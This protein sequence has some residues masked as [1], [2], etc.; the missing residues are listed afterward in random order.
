MNEPIGWVI[1]AAV[2]FMV[3]GMFSLSSQIHRNLQF[4]LQILESNQKA[5]ILSLEKLGALFAS[6]AHA[7]SSNRFDRRTRQ[8][9]SP[10]AQLSRH[11]HNGERRQ[12]PGRRRQ[13]FATA[14]AEGFLSAC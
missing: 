13:D 5:L 8:R 6:Y 12:S 9:R 3:L 11:S 14:Q 2:G 1:L 10:V 4:M 7:E